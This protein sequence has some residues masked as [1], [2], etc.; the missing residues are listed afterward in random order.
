[1]EFERNQVTRK[2]LG[3]IESN[4]LTIGRSDWRTVLLTLRAASFIRTA[5]TRLSLSGK[6]NSE[7]PFSLDSAPVA[8]V[9]RGL[10]IGRITT[11]GWCRTGT[12]KGRIRPSNPHGYTYRI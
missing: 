4:H 8:K 5:T 2:I 6:R 11:N 1:M 9:R 10:F 7:N 3:C 12:G